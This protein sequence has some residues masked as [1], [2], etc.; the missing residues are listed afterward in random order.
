M[1]GLFCNI[2]CCLGPFLKFVPF[3]SLQI[4]SLLKNLP[5]HVTGQRVCSV[6]SIL[7]IKFHLTSFHSFPPPDMPAFPASLHASDLRAALYITLQLDPPWFLKR[8]FIPLQALRQQVVMQVHKR[9]ELFPCRISTQEASP[10]KSGMVVDWLG[11]GGRGRG[12][13]RG[14][15]SPTMTQKPCKVYF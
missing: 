5:T 11:G 9:K 15:D 13:M 10:V 6:I 4:G 14:E 3:L 7:E 12:S 1:F 2:Y 8:V